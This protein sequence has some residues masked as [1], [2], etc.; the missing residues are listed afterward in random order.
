MNNELPPGGPEAA[1]GPVDRA[2]LEFEL[3]P[4]MLAEVEALAR[5]CHCT[6]FEM[7]VRLVKSRLPSQE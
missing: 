3:D 7:C 1:G 5:R 2:Y 4:H 6:P